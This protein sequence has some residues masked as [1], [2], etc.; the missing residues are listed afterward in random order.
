MA[1]GWESCDVDRR[2]LAVGFDPAGYSGGGLCLRV[3]NPELNMKIKLPSVCSWK[4]SAN[5]FLPQRISD[6]LGR[7]ANISILV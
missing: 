2:H 1:V 6:S 3:L 5:D 7:G 4:V